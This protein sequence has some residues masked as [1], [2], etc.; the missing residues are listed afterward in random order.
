MAIDNSSVCEVQD[1]SHYG[2]IEV[3]N[4][5]NVSFNNIVKVKM[6]GRQTTV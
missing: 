1:Q 3:L 2:G 5:M 4:S 6:E